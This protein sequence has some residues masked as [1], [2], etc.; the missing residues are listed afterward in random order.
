L[1]ESKGNPHFRNRTFTVRVGLMPWV[2]NEYLHNLSKKNGGDLPQ[3][4]IDSIFRV[5]SAERERAFVFSVIIHT[6]YKNKVVVDYKSETVRRKIS[7]TMG[8]SEKSYFRHIK[9]CEKAGFLVIDGKNLRFKSH[10]DLGDDINKEVDGCDVNSYPLKSSHAADVQFKSRNFEYCKLLLRYSYIQYAEHR[11]LLNI[12]S[13]IGRS[14]NRRFSSRKNELSKIRTKN[15]FVHNENE[16][17][18]GE[19]NFKAN[20]KAENFKHL[21]SFIHTKCRGS[22]AKD[23]ASSYVIQRRRDEIPSI[24]DSLNIEINGKGTISKVEAISRATT[25]G[26]HKQTNDMSEYHLSDGDVCSRVL[27]ERERLRN[28]ELDLKIRQI[29]SKIRFKKTDGEKISYYEELNKLNKKMNSPL[30]DEFIDEI[31][32]YGGINPASFDIERS[33]YEGI[34]KTS[35]GKNIVSETSKREV[36]LFK[37]MKSINSLNL[38]HL[39]KE[40]FYMHIWEMR[41]LLNG[42]ILSPVDYY[43]LL[44]S[45]FNMEY[46]VGISDLSVMFGLSRSQCSRTMSSMETLGIMKKDRRFVF[47]SSVSKPNN[48]VFIENMRKEYSLLTEK[49][50]NS[51]SKAFGRVI[52][53]SGCL[54][55]EIT[56]HKTNKVKI[57]MRNDDIYRDIKK[58][59][60]LSISKLYPNIQKNLKAA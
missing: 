47:L 41:N 44:S 30:E 40:A 11:N 60:R 22:E 17:N 23:L 36:D 2:Y 43:T 13:N 42:Q 16:K 20:F 55:Y 26:N 56:S 45:D 49:S 51:E 18:I 10:K 12:K 27:S 53:S 50:V 34:G 58:S 54:L 32:A 15:L 33:V 5:D 39:N 28:E 35:I 24:I 4:F 29:K 37:Q 7:S 25:L 9:S 19:R 52:Y 3:H 1:S 8:L 38:S 21:Y 6:L 59:N 14:R 57:H 48:K 46:R 31:S